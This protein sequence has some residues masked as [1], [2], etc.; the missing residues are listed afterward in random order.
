MKHFGQLTLIILGISIL[1]SA[2][3]KEEQVPSIPPGNM[4]FTDSRDGQVYQI[5]TIGNKAES[6]TWFAENLNFEKANS[7]WYDNNAD[8]GAVYGRLYNWDAALTAC[9]D[10]WHLPGDDEWK[11]LEMNLGMSQGEADKSGGRGSDEGAKLKEEGPEHWGAY[12]EA[13]TNSSGFTALPG[14]NRDSDFFELGTSGNWWT[15]TE[16]DSFMGLSWSRNLSFV[17]HKV[18]R[19]AIYFES[20]LSVRCVKD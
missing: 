14:G 6:Q 5:V 20:A 11:I 2:C 13:A 16:F 12:N 19:D 18:F 8:T 4:T 17:G 7:W 9:P 3:K 15:A 1:F 10:G